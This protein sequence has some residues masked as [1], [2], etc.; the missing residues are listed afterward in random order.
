MKYVLTNEQMRNADENAIKKSSA[1][2]VME[3][4]GKA[5]FDRVSARV[6]KILCV[7]GGGNNGGDGFV[8]AR[9][10]LEQGREVLVLSRAEK[11]S[12]L[13][14]LNREKY[15]ALGGK[16]TAEFPKT[17]DVVVDCLLG[18]GFQGE[19]K[20][21]VAEQIQK[22]NELK[23]KGAYVISVDIPS[24]VNGDSGLSKLAVEAD[25]TLCIGEWKRGNLLQDGLTYCGKRKLLDIGIRAVVSNEDAGEYLTLLEGKDVKELL[26]K[27]VRNSHKGTYGKVAI[28]AGSE[29]YTGASYLALKSASKSGVGYVTLF[30]PKTV[31]ES[32]YLKVPEALIFPLNGGG[33]VEFCVSDFEKICKN[34]AVA[35]GM[36]M[37]VSEATYQGAK[38]LLEHYEGK[39]ILDAD[40]LNAIAKYGSADD[41]LSKKADV[42][43]TPHLKEFERL[44]H[45]SMEKVIKT[46]V[47]EEKRVSEEFGIKILL[48]GASTLLTD[49]KS[50]FLNVTGN[51]AQAKAGS[52]D[53]LSGLI[54]GLCAQGASLLDGA[55]AGSYLVGKSAEI[56]TEKLTEY[57][58][59]PTDFIDCFGLAFQSVLT[60]NADVKR[61][62]E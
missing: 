42:L 6:G 38:Y 13:A 29:K 62:A 37:T 43:I 39:L 60:E 33:S 61:N 44:F 8:C 16:I 51:S 50:C 27:R 34:D 19:L 56:A 52:G 4:A 22:I 25:E 10:L 1:E 7:C 35:Y 59:T 57:V 53:V 49:G 47:S 11:L 40:G 12:E 23:R 32:F 14:K 58:A 5:V 24:G 48:K 21:N 54:G 15:L 46:P 41:F 26:P 9:Y 18:T 3:R 20:E 55:K 31:A 28:V 36:G 45:I 2:A 30:T 17:V